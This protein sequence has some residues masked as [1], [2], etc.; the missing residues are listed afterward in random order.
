MNKKILHLIFCLV[1]TNCFAID[2]YSPGDSLWVWAKGGLNIRATPNDTAKVIGRVTNGSLVIVLEDQDHNYPY[3]IEV[4][5]RSAKTGDNE[6]G[7]H[8]NFKLNGYWAKIKYNGTIGYVFDGYLSKLPTFIGH[9]YDE[10]REEDFH[11]L[12][13]K[14]RNK[15]LKQIGQNKYDLQDHKFVRYIFGN[16]CIIDITG[17]GNYW[18]KEMLFP[19]HLSL[20]EGYLIYAHTMKMETDT[21]LE[22]GED[23]L[24]F[25]VE[26]GILTIKKVG[27]FLIIYEEHS[28]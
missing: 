14:Q 2:Y 19:D 11:V 12:A 17:G 23:Y 18:Q 7:Y 27:S 16:G 10:Q 28:C 1:A 26:M 8:P 22:K 6:K 20:I 9:R 3:T 24:I 21:L 25:K 5:K 13:L 15:L 4:I